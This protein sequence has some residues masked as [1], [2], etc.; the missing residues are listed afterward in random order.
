MRNAQRAGAV[1]MV[2]ILA[3]GGFAQPTWALQKTA[4][5]TVGPFTGTVVDAA[6]KPVAGATIWLA[7]FAQ[8]REVDAVPRHTDLHL[9]AT[10]KSDAKGRFQFAEVKRVGTA[11]R[12]WPFFLSARDSQGRIGGQ[13]HRYTQRVD[14][15]SAKLY[16]DMQLMVQEVKDYR[17]RLIDTA[18]QPIAKARIRPESYSLQQP[19]EKFY[20]SSAFPPP[21]KDELSVETGA[22]GTFTI[23][24]LP[25]QGQV[26]LTILAAGFGKPLATLNLK[27]SAAIQIGR[28][29]TV[30]G[31][32][33]CETDPRAAAG[34]RIQLNVSPF[35]GQTGPRRMESDCQV[36]YVDSEVTQKDGT[37]RFDNVPP[38]PC[39]LWP[40]M[41]E[42]SPYYVENVDRLDVRS[43][44][45]TSVSLVLKL[46][47]KVQGRV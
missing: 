44:A 23:H 1:A 25:V 38:G 36:S 2:L 32:V 46:A 42:T 13:V 24:N 27:K 47:V 6:G 34:I 37:F 17:G 21:L 40:Q 8:P 3:V 14:M 33:V 30:R 12:A 10:T 16:Q 15:T 45:T 35:L 19:A 4:E 5:K 9:V 43:G 39:S 18:G 41:P 20:T 11:E 26:T 31:S 29:G 7:G 22:D 28:A